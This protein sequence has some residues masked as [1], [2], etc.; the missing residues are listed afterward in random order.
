M[1]RP[2]RPGHRRPVRDAGRNHHQPVRG[3]RAGDI[4][5]RSIRPAALASTD[6]TAW[7]RFLRGLSHYYQQ[8]KADFET[9]I[10]AVQGGHRA[11]S[12]AVDRARLSRHHPGAGR[13]VSDGSG[14]PANCGP[15]RWSLA[16]SS[17]RLDPRSSFAFS[18]LAYLHAMQ[19]HH[20]AA[21]GGRKAGGRVEPVRHGRA[22]RAWNM[23]SRD[24]RASQAI[25]LFSTAVAARQ[26]RSPL[27]MGGVERVQPLSARA[28][29]ASLSWSREALYSIPIISR[30]S[31]CGRRRWRN[32][33]ATEEAARAAEV[34]LGQYPDFTV[35]RHL[36]NFRWRSRP[37]SPITV[38]GF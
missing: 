29:D 11:R 17:V 38:T 24:R 19:G 32:W 16:E 13:A 35:E 21:H 1:D 15:R 18:I 9:S 33:A 3:D 26:Q 27:P 6:L 37:T 30:C 28:Y 22:R 10:G 25:E 31:R 12:G 36:R 5:R 34:L 23:P 20:E 8:T 4:S 14:A 7:D 2:I